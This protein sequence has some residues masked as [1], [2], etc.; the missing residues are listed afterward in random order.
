MKR[1]VL[2]S[3]IALV[4][5]AA[6]Y[7]QDFGSIMVFADDQMS[8]CNM[9]VTGAG[10]ITVHIFVANGITPS[11]GCFYQ[12]VEGGGFS[13]VFGSDAPQ[14]A[15]PVVLGNSRDGVTVGYGTCVDPPIYVFQTTYFVTSVP[16]P[17]AYLR[18]ERH[19][20]LPQF[21]LPG[22]LDCSDPFPLEYEVPGGQ[23]TF[24]PDGTCLCDVPN[25][26][27]TWGK[28]KAIYE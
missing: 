20:D 15:W 7:A 14:G 19:P 8:S 23:L 25:H 4:M 12:L 11:N 9:T 17:C 2:L 13:G 22:V 27:S 21:T 3:I 1:I 18:V 28:I 24:N 26:P 6:V 10:Q 16:P 5:A